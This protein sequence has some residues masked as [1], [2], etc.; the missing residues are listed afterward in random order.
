MITA[1]VDGSLGKLQVVCRGP[2]NSEKGDVENIKHLKMIR[3]H[4]LR[5]DRMGMS[6]KIIFVG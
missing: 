3:Y 2:I 1:A 4:S 6:V 5:L